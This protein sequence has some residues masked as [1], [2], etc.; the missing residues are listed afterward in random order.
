MVFLPRS[1]DQNLVFVK[2]LLAE[3]I[4]SDC[5]ANPH[6]SERLMVS[7]TPLIELDEPYPYPI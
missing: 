3:P 4:S 2:F 5:G 6:S 7:E 1:P